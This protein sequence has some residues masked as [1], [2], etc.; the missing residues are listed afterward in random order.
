MQLSWP[1]NYVLWPHRD[2]SLAA[3]D[4]PA[5]RGSCNW[6]LQTM[7][8]Y[9]LLPFF[10]ILL[11]VYTYFSKSWLLQIMLHCSSI[12]SIQFIIFKVMDLI[13]SDIL[14]FHTLC[15]RRGYR[16]TLGSIELWVK[17]GQILAE[18]SCKLDKFASSFT[19]QW[20]KGAN[21]RP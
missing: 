3:M 7:C 4:Q 8:S 5:Q 12:G 9:T 6:P 19:I 21:L 1:S 18:R 2:P 15:V 14:W 13:W 16:P 11:R 17:L 10:T 20:T